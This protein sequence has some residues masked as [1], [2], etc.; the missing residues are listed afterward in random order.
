MSASEA[1]RLLGRDRGTVARWIAD[2]AP[3]VS[4]ASRENGVEW[5]LDLCAVLGW[6]LARERQAERARVETKLGPELDRLRR[7]L[8]A[9][10]TEGEQHVPWQEAR[11]RRTLAEARLRELEVAEREG[12]LVDP[13]ARDLEWVA[14]IAT[15]KAHLLAAPSKLALD[16]AASSEPRQCHELVEDQIREALTACADSAAGFSWDEAPPPG[17]LVR[18]V[19]TSLGLEV[20]ARPLEA[21]G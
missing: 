11:R 5:K 20:V 4:A 3:T 8:E 14:A 7:A 13:H 6:L 10:G 17:A 9:A 19:A 2:G 21:A 18:M 1:A 16:L 12:E 15:A